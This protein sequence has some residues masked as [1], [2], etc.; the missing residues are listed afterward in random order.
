MKAIDIT[1]KAIKEAK[2][3]GL[4]SPVAFALG[5]LE[6]KYDLLLLEVKELQDKLGRLENNNELP[7]IEDYSRGVLDS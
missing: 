3:Y 5:V 1:K 2:G 6:A 4:C 7:I